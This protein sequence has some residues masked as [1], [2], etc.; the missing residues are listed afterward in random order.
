MT[1]AP[2][3]LD[4]QATT[5]VDPSVRKAMMPFLGDLFGNPHSSDHSFGWE[6]ARA[7]KDARASVAALINADD[8]EIVF[9]SGATESCNPGFRGVANRSD[10]GQRDRI[11][12]LATEH[13]AVL[14]TVLDLGRSGFDAIV[15]PVDSD[16]LTPSIPQTW[17]TQVNRL[18]THPST[19]RLAIHLTRREGIDM[20]PENPLRKLENFDDSACDGGCCLLRDSRWLRKHGEG[21]EHRR[22]HVQP[23]RT[24]ES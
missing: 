8:D 4:Y 6:A 11:V 3:Y 9:T 20:L 16:G 14:E 22:R 24:N 13:P 10:N 5:P 1:G 19:N 17:A 12:T 23:H 7:I 2:V 21:V 18:T 15:L